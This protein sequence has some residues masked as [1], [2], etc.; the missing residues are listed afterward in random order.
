MRY[1]KEDLQ[2]ALRV[3]RQGGIIVYPTDT[4]WGT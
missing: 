3:L 2:A 4:V 1:D